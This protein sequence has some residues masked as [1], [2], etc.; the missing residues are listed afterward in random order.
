MSK[1]TIANFFCFVIPV[2]LSLCIACAPVN[3]DPGRATVSSVYS[4]SQTIGRI[5]SPEVNESSGVAASRCQSDVFWTHNDSGDEAFIYAFNSAGENLGTWKVPNAENRDWEDIALS[6]DSSGKCFLYIGEIGDNKLLWPEHMIYRVAEPQIKTEGRATTSKNAL[7]TSPAEVLRYLYPDGDHDAETLTVHP[8]SG[9]IYV[10]TKQV[11]GPAGVYR[12]QPDFASGGRQ[13]AVKVAE[14]SV[15][16]VPN[17][18][19]TGG[20][21]SPDGQRVVVCDYR[22]A[23]ELVLPEG[24]TEFDDIWKASPRSFEIGK[25]KGGESIGY[26]PDGSSVIATSEGRNPPIIIA[27]RL[28]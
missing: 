13:T 3:S 25:R 9:D 7:A 17:G 5:R 20:D 14:I 1:K 16:S 8:V 19:L 18:L 26:S 12:L 27:R 4:A 24:S 28:K 2:P 23:Y 21:I 22:Q 11:S 6:K 10:L 15:P